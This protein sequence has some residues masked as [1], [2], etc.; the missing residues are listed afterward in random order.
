MKRE[1]L[2]QLMATIQGAIHESA[3]SEKDKLAFKTE[4]LKLD[5]LESER[6]AAN[7]AAMHQFLAQM[8]EVM[9]MFFNK[10]N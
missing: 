8:G 7:D 1:K 6:R 4:Q 3:Q 9:K 5:R 2:D 10:Q